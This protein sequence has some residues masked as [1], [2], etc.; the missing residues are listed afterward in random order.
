MAGLAELLLDGEHRD[1][2]VADCV[3]LVED[4]VAK[5]SGWKGMALRT[6]LA[7]IRAKRPDFLVRSTHWLLPQFLAALDPLY[8]RQAGLRAG[9]TFR[10]YL[11]EHHDEAT[12]ALLQI[13]DQRV[14]GT[15]NQF[16]KKTY[17]RFRDDAEKE[18][19]IL[20]P[21]FGDLI[22]RHLPATARR[23]T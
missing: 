2:V 1:P 23:K 5:R 18:V 19:E 22:D 15:P 14:A 21:A 16:V 20:L 3:Q 7:V 9:G 13:A 17:A 10:D 11:V 12:P 8:Q 6:G 4:Y